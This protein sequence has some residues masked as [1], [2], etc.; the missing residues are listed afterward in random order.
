MPWALGHRFGETHPEPREA[1]WGRGGV[2]A[3]WWGNSLI[4]SRQGSLIWSGAWRAGR[5]MLS[6]SHESPPGSPPRPTLIPPS[7]GRGGLTVTQSTSHLTPSGLIPVSSA[8]QLRPAPSWG[9]RWGPPGGHARPSQ[10]EG[11]NFLF[12]GASGL[13]LPDPGAFPEVT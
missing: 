5:V 1:Q 10:T 11:Q 6:L 12:P 3:A 9:H 2:L 8:G 13:P 4:Q 7:P